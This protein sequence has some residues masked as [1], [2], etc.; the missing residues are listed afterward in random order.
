M[1][2]SMGAKHTSGRSH[3]LDDFLPQ[4]Q[5]ASGPMDW[6][7]LL[8]RTRAYMDKANRLRSMVGKV[9]NEKDLAGLIN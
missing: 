1:A 3:K 4:K 2:T 8:S 7:D 6:K 9:V 5:L